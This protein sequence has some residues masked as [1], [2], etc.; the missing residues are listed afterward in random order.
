M[1]ITAFLLHISFEVLRLKKAADILARRLVIHNY[2]NIG[3]FCLNCFFGQ[4]YRRGTGK[5]ASVNFFCQTSSP[6][7]R[8]TDD[9]AVCGIH[10]AVCLNPDSNLPAQFKIN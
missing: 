1:K 7:L 4:Q 8:L 3:F 2:R 5:P 9:F 6:L 10:F